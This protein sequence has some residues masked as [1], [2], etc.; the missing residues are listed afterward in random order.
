[1]RMTVLKY[2]GSDS[3]LFFFYILVGQTRTP[4]L[5]AVERSPVRRNTRHPPLRRSGL[6][7]YL[8]ATFKQVSRAIRQVG[9]QEEGEHDPEGQPED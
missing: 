4:A 3:L 2:H 9:A 6:H 8:V 1:M 5:L 7:E